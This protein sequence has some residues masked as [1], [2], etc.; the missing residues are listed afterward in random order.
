MIDRRSAGGRDR[1]LPLVSVIVP[2][3]DGVDLLIRCVDALL[4]QDYP[5]DRFEVIIA[6]NGSATSP[7]GAVPEDPRVTVID[8]P[9]PGSYAARNAALKRASGEILA[10][11]DADCLPDRGWLRTAAGFLVD[12]PDVAMIGGRVRLEYRHG[13]PRNGPEWFEFVQGFPQENYLRTGFAVTANMVTRRAVFDRIG[14]F[15]ASLLSGGDAE[16]GR[17]V[18]SAGLGQRFLSDAV[19][20]HP[21]RD[22]WDELATKTRRTTTG[23]VR[24]TA[25]GARPRGRVARLLAGQLVRSVILPISVVRRHDLPTWSARAR[26][27][28]T[29]WRVD[30]IIAGILVRGLVHP[31]GS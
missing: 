28:L 29:R 25:K 19:V 14:D 30:A 10:F 23:I 11:T 8:E 22:T 20:H 31:R 21:A 12:N 27:L 18:R 16:W 1:D 4:G 7:A 26:F 15:D 17:R 3:K 9:R 13:E 24:R 5:P 6:D 2:V